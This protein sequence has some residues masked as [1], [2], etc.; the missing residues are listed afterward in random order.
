MASEILIR[1]AGMAA[2]SEGAG[3]LAPS[4]AAERVSKFISE[5]TGKVVQAR[6]R[7][8]NRILSNQLSQEGLTEEDK[9]KMYKELEKKRFGYVYLNRRRRLKAEADLTKT[10]DDTS[11]HVIQLDEIA[12]TSQ[13]AFESGNL[14]FDLQQ[15]VKEI[16]TN[17]TPP[18]PGV[19]SEGNNIGNGYVIPNPDSDNFVFQHSGSQEDDLLSIAVEKYY[20]QFFN[21]ADDETPPQPWSRDYKEMGVIDIDNLPEDLQFVTENEFIDIL[22]SYGPDEESITKFQSHIDNTIKD[23]ENKRPGENINFKWDHTYNNMKTFSAQGNMTSIARN[24]IIGDRV[25]EDDLIEG[26]QRGTYKDLGIE[27]TEEQV[28]ALDTNGG[29]VTKDDSIKIASEI[30]DKNPEL[31][32]DLLSS[33]LTSVTSDIYYRSLSD[34]TYES[35]VSNPKFQA[36]FMTQEQQEQKLAD[37][38]K[39]KEQLRGGGARIT[40]TGG[41]I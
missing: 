36:Q 5:G 14:P 19:D 21:L 7:E 24:P 20:Q 15:G 2:L 32:S 3:K 41:T 27:L 18:V 9:D 35:L 38:E 1:G 28:K 16:I 31:L 4:Q 8:F 17:Q 29:K 12:K 30:I 33:Y 22:S 39:Q 13:K 23:A 40:W 11:Q 34:E 10:G 25:F 6:N 37:I 26:L